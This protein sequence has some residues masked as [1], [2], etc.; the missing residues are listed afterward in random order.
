[1]AGGTR[2]IYGMPLTGFYG[3]FIVK[4]DSLGRELWLQTVAAG[5]LRGSA[6]DSSSNLYIAGQIT[7]L[8]P[9]ANSDAF[10]AKLDSDGN[11]LWDRRL[12][13]SENDFG[14][15]VTVDDEGNAYFSGSTVGLIGET[16]TNTY[17]A[18][19]AR[20]TP[21][22]D[23]TWVTQLGTLGWYGTSVAVAPDQGIM[24][25]GYSSRTSYLARIDSAGNV[26]WN[27]ILDFS[28]NPE[29]GTYANDVACDPFGNIFVVGQMNHPTSS[30]PRDAF[31]AKYDSAGN[32]IWRKQLHATS[33]N[34]LL[35]VAV[36]NLGNVFAAGQTGM[37]QGASADNYDAIWAKYD[38]D[39]NLRWFEQFGTSG[40]DFLTGIAV[41]ALGHVYLAGGNAYTVNDY[42]EAD[43]DAFVARYD[44]IP[45]PSGSF[46][47]ITGV[48]FLTRFRY[49]GRRKK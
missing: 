44:L 21:D 24:L 11:I 2:S 12:G 35:V 9:R 27:T 29:D 33:G 17:D 25:T 34:S 28:A 45:E 30:F 42:Y 22:G 3:D 4:Y 47:V 26:V 6:L 15:D 48:Q 5:L 18:F 1:M 14:M 38:S 49:N 8:A 46:L 23:L 36:D 31:V 39:G 16:E 32:L 20:Y 41:D 13:S 10:I 40:N 43:V 19:L 7:S 37:F